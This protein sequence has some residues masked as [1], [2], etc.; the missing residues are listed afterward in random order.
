MKLILL[1]LFIAAISCFFIFRGASGK[2]V[3]NDLTVKT[4]HQT[5]IFLNKDNGYNYLSDS[6]FFHNW[7]PFIDAS[8]RLEKDLTT[9]TKESNLTEYKQYLKA[10][11]LNWGENDIEKI[12][13]I[14]EN[15]QAKIRDVSG[16]LM[17][18]TLFLVKTTGKEEFNAYYT[19]QKAIVI[20]KQELEFLSIKARR[21]KVE[22]TLVHEYCH[23]YTR[24]NTPK[25]EEL[26]KVIGFSRLD[27]L[28]IPDSVEKIR[29]TN[30]D[31]YHQNYKIDITMKDNTTQPVVM[32][33]T[34]K[35]DKYDGIR[36]FIGIFSV[37]FDY[38][39]NSFYTIKTEENNTSVI[40]KKVD[41]ATFKNFN[42][43]IG[44]NTDYI[45]G[46]DEIIA[47]NIK[48]LICDRNDKEKSAKRSARNNEILAQIE[49]IIK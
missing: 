18:D 2:E 5:I 11:C 40:N 37:L 19:N 28:E 21:A 16:S 4:K 8:L 44:S 48:V 29:V 7:S 32:L 10:Q 13:S 36:G 42:E 6:P 17:L 15:A 1:G 24:Y 14:L 45:L 3:S 30:P 34:S 41:S 47:E 12:T 22:Q 20:P 38:V 23:I 43:Q 27:T 9:G 31:F 46:P 35:Y 25:R 33:L 49:K 26:Y 39:D